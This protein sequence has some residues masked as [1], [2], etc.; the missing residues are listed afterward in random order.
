MKKL[1][2]F[3]VVAVVVL[4][5]AVMLLV[6]FGIGPIIKTGM[7]TIGPKA[8]GVEMTVESVKVSPLTGSAQIKGLFIGNPEGFKSKSLVE[9]KNFEVSIDL[10]SLLTDTVVIRKIIIE[11]PL[12]TYE[13]H[14]KTD[15]IKEI[16]KNVE[17]FSG[18]TE[19]PTGE[20]AVEKPAEEPKKKKPGKKVIIEQLAIRDAQVNLKIAGLPTAPVPILDI[21]KTNIG[22]KGGGT[23]LAK[24]VTEIIS[25][26]YESIVSAVANVGDIGEMA[27]G[28]LKGA[29]DTL[30]GT[31][32]SLKGV[33]DTGGAA[34]DTA[35][36]AVKSIGGLFKKKK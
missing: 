33:K 3:L 26:L 35:S 2:K 15:N 25:A 9:L 12:F 27:S 32:D 13:R 28:A 14:L 21:E 31:T 8:T 4:I 5:V 1:L 36:D 29:G 20:A 11:K 24:A 18:P 10:K 16:Q 7:E 30:K 17:N 34:L 23:S 19:E 6:S 22:K